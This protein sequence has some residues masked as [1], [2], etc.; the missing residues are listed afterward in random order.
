[1]QSDSHPARRATPTR[2]SSAS[3]RARRPRRAPAEARRAARLGRGARLA[4]RRS[5]WPTPTGKRW[6][7]VGLGARE[8]LHPRARPRGG[9]GGVRARAASSPRACS[10]G[11]ARR[12]RRRR[13]PAALVEGTLLRDYRFE[14]YKS[15]PRDR[16]TAD[17]PPKQ[18]ERLIVVRPGRARQ[19]PSREAAVVAEAVNRARDLQNRPGNDLTP[20]ALGEHA[21]ALGR[22]DRG[23]DASRSRDA[24]GIAA[25]GMGAFA[26]VAQGSEQEPALITLRYEGPGASGPDAR[27]RGQG[28]DV[29]QR[30][31]LAEARREDGG[32][33]VR[34]V[35]RRRRDRGGRGDRP[36]AAAGAAA[37][38]RGRHREPARAGARSSPAT[39]SPR[40][41][42]RRSRSTTPTPRAG[43]CWPTA[44]ATPSPQGAER[45]VDLATLTGAVIVA[46]G[47]TYAG[48]MS[49]DDE[50]AE[51]VEA[52]GA[53]TGEIVWRLPLHEEYDEL[54]KG[55]LR[56]PRQRPRSA[57]GGDDRRRRASS[58]TS[59]ARCPG[60]TWTSPARPGIW[61][62][63]TSARAPPATA[64][65]CWSS[66][67]AL[68]LRLAA[69]AGQADWRRSLRRERAP[70]RC[71]GRR[72]CG[73]RRRGRS[74]SSVAADTAT[75][76][77]NSP[78]R[79]GTRAAAPSPPG[80][81]DADRRAARPGRHRERPRAATPMPIEPPDLSSPHL[82]LKICVERWTVW[83]GA[84]AAHR[85]ARGMANR[86]ASDQARPNEAGGDPAAGARLLERPRADADGADEQAP[87]GVRPHTSGSRG[88]GESSS[89]AVGGHRARRRGRE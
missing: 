4:S 5:R 85:R 74:A 38:G 16:R 87:H 15:A 63:P 53:R 9:R 35:R 59:S 33:E 1:M 79:R 49:N 68:L 37:G 82:R 56:R 11:A 70:R 17:A 39:S 64:C 55:K 73:R 32:D 58:R 75:P 67:P 18:L 78:R 77:A 72:R 20:T 80:V 2:S 83:K 36:A 46:L 13:S 62:A 50:L 43:W 41:T 7:L 66:W 54:I 27:L 57:Q 61:A 10:A 19:A 24:S 45:I 21:K 71:P 23:P 69:C 12:R 29:R 89:A 42:A 47:S 28:R 3:S 88:F 26:A 31:H 76:S 84:A 6:L 40:P 34:H 65:G 51:R 81:A 8:E 30:R 86:V 25:R 44:S 14:R 22:R 48:L 60:R 52:A